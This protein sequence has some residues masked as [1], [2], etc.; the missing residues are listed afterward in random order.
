MNSEEESDSNGNDMICTPPDVAEIAN[1]VSSELLPQKS[2]ERY[3]KERN[4]FLTWCKEKKVKEYTENVLLA[5][6]IEKS[7]KLKSSTLWSMYSM[8][9]S[10]LILEDNVDI[11]KFAKL[12]SFLKRKSV[13][14]KAKK[15][16]VFTREQIN[17]FLEDAPD[18]TFLMIKVQSVY[19]SSFLN[20]RLNFY[21]LF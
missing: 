17:T 7:K 8:L 14:H 4:C 20:N 11:S 21:R 19:F 10:T 18:E 5:Y 16:Q 2:K 3:E 9:K 1:S 6:F 13:G 15:S 12:Q